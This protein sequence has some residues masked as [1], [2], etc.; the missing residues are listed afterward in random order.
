[1]RNT[2]THCRSI[3]EDGP[4]YV[5]QCSLD[6]ALD[7]RTQQKRLHSGVSELC[8]FSNLK[9]YSWGPLQHGHIRSIIWL[10]DDDSFGIPPRYRPRLFLVPERALARRA[11]K[12]RVNQRENLHWYPPALKRVAATRQCLCPGA[13]PSQ[14]AASV[15]NGLKHGSIGFSMH[16]SSE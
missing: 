7:R 13:A 3:K 8:G 12:L 10:K 14:R 1:M 4:M 11:I 9:N 6:D 5:K 16:R 2:L 15:G